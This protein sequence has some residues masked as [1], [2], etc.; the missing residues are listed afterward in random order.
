[1]IYLENLVK[2]FYCNNGT[3]HGIEK[4]NFFH[5]VQ[6]AFEES[7]FETM[8]DFLYSILGYSINDRMSVQEVVKER[9]DFCRRSNS[10]T[11]MK[12][13]VAKYDARNQNDLT[14]ILSSLGALGIQKKAIS[15]LGNYK[16]L[17]VPRKFLNKDNC[18]LLMLVSDYLDNSGFTGLNVFNLKLQCTINPNVD[19]VLK[20]FG[21]T[22]DRILKVKYDEEYKDETII[23]DGVVHCYN[24]DF[25]EEETRQFLVKLYLMGMPIIPLYLRDLFISNLPKLVAFGSI[26]DSL[27]DVLDISYLTGYT[28]NQ[29]IGVYGFRLPNPEEMYSL[30]GGFFYVTNVVY[31]TKKGIDGYVTFDKKDF[32]HLIN[33]GGILDLNAD[34]LVTYRE[35]EDFKNSMKVERSKIFGE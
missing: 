1:M 26:G 25:T 30:C 33:T 12:S 32:L 20:K 27:L 9:K 5:E 7:E 22:Y 21:L 15:T 8:S 11:Y 24:E 13:L 18:A 10:G 31:Y 4:C 17:N 23:K 34:E 28:V 35:M 16:A 2:L 14:E 19:D 6:K 29:L 3:F